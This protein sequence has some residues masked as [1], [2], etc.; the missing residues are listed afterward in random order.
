[1]ARYGITGTVMVAMFLVATPL[2]ASGRPSTWDDLVLKKSS[3]SSA[4]YLL[5][6]ADFRPYT[7]VMFDP[8]EVAFKK[9]WLRDYNSTKMS[10]SR[11]LTNADVEKA[12]EKI[13][14]GF[15]DTFAKVYSDAGYQVVT[16]P[17]P[18][19][20]RMR[21]GVVDV[22]VNAPDIQ[23][24]GRVRTYAEQAGQATLFL[25]ARDSETGALLGRVVEARAA[26]DTTVWIRNGMTNRND[27]A[28][29]FKDWANKSVAGLNTLKAQS[30]GP[31]VSAIAN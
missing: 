20:L 9:N 18:D 21:T 16:T 8:T 15:A 2:A 7:K 14:T 4:I 22:T 13:R 6:D 17:G 28:R 1:M 5:P 19:V 24:A 29:L 23:T 11:R 10:L 30:S 31:R 26:G 12:T 27:F 25:E 3:R